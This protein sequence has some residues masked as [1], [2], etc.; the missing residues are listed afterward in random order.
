MHRRGI[1]RRPPRAQKRTRGEAFVH[2]H[3]EACGDHYSHYRLH[4]KPQ[5]GQHLAQATK[6][7]TGSSRHLPHPLR[8]QKS[9]ETSGSH[10]GAPQ[11]TS[12]H[13][14]F[15]RVWEGR[16]RPCRR[17]GKSPGKCQSMAPKRGPGVARLGQS[18]T[19]A[20]GN[21]R[22]LTLS[23]DTGCAQAVHSAHNGTSLI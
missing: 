19:E 12:D 5:K 14:Q 20:V 8:A 13:R 6:R 15:A 7:S 2:G 22:V 11:C 16:S 17:A 4:E 21:K 9:Q 3:L 18:H 23:A 1:L 10:R